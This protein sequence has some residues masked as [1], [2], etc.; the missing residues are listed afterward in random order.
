MD[1]IN[2]HLKGLSSAPKGLPDAQ[3]KVIERFLSELQRREEKEYF[4][5][6]NLRRFLQLLGFDSTK[7]SETN[8]KDLNAYRAVQ[9]LTVTRDFSKLPLSVDE[10]QEANKFLDSLIGGRL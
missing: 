7:I 4:E 5:A 3:L 6:R 8:L 1:I 9:S 10:I 2:E